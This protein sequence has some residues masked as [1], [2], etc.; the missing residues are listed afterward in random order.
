MSVAGQTGVWYDTHGKQE[1]RS[2]IGCRDDTPQ[3]GGRVDVQS[4]LESQEAGELVEIRCLLK[5]DCVRSG[6]G[7]LAK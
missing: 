2:R 6:M 5:L 3:T 1:G 4:N 7:S